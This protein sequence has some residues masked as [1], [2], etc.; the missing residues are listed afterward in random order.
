MPL[1]RFIIRLFKKDQAK[2]IQQENE[3]LQIELE[4][5]KKLEQEIKDNHLKD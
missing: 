2:S 4:V 5:L 1:K 3:R